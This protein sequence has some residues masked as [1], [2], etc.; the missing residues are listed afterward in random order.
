MPASLLLAAWNY[1]SLR[2]RALTRLLN[3]TL[4]VTLIAFLVCLAFASWLARRLLG[5]RDAAANAVSSEGTIR[6]DFPGVDAPD[7]LGDVAR[8]FS[9][10]LARLG[11]YTNYLRTLA[12]KLAHEIRTPLTIVRSSRRS[13]SNRQSNQPGIGRVTFTA[14]SHRRSSA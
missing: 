14:A 8:S 6:G 2:D 10:L 5:L 13:L 12:G 4:L 7:E 3:L 9:A 1:V 11:G